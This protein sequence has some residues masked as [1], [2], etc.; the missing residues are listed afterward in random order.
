MRL[1]VLVDDA[2]G[3]T[4][5][6]SNRLTFHCVATRRA[7]LLASV[8]ESDIM[9]VELKRPELAKFIDE[10]V[11]AGHFP[12]PDAAIEAAVEHMMLVREFDELDDETI[13]AINRAE[14]ELDRGEGIDFD[15]FAKEM[16]SKFPAE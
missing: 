6:V 10:A 13:A 7:Y 12:S 3:D 11:K 5:I 8:I 14:E 9:Q 2:K 1:M 16:R 15:Q 4:F